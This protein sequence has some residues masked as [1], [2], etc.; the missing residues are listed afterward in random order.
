MITTSAVAVGPTATGVQRVYPLAYW[1]IF[2]S[3]ET[4]A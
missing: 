1:G 4:D 2:S 3:S